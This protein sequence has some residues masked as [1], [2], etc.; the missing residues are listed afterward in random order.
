MNLVVD[1]SGS[2]FSEEDQKLFF[3]E[4]DYIANKVPNINLIQF[5][6]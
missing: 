6:F 3:S 4:I 2:C 5:F 1:T